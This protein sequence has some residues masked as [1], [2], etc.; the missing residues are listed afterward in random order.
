MAS[1]ENPDV[2]LEAMEEAKNQSQRTVETGCTSGKSLCSGENSQGLL[3]CGC[4]TLC[5]RRPF[6]TSARKGVTGE[7]P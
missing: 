6:N 3:A 2:Y 5:T 4:D 7:C 1:P